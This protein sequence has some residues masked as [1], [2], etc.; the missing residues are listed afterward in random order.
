MTK[1]TSEITLIVSYKKNNFDFDS[2]VGVLRGYFD[3]IDILSAELD[4][5]KRRITIEY[6][7]IKK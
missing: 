1:E 4:D 6:P 2:F 7:V 5:D 3:N